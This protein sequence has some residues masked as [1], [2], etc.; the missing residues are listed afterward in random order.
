M[1]ST[2]APL[3]VSLVCIFIG[4][5]VSTVAMEKQLSLDASCGP[6]TVFANAVVSVATMASGRVAKRTASI[7]SVGWVAPTIPLRWHAIIALLTFAMATLSNLSYAHGVNVP[8]HV[9]VKGPIGLPVGMVIGS[10]FL[11]KRYSAQHV[12]AIA[13][14][15][16]G[17]ACVAGF[18]GRSGDDSV[19]LAML[20]ASV[21]MQAVL[22][23][24]QET[25]YA[26]FGR[27]SAETGEPLWREAMF[28]SSLGSLVL[29]PLLV[30]GKLAG[31]VAIMAASPIQTAWFLI[32]VAFCFVGVCGI[33]SL[34]P[35][36]SAL[37]TT[38][39]IVARKAITLV[40]SVFL[41]GSDFNAEQL[42]GAC[43]VFAGVS[44]YA[45]APTPRIAARRAPAEKDVKDA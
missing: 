22:G 14:V 1:T 23:A 5:I 2:R 19:G 45:G 10:I 24:L 32:D 9:V 42:G 31:S 8:T 33:Y 40:I 21:L 29:F 37:T 6:I 39:V 3:L 36:T 18:H 27:T 11:R 26:R 20:G 41:L 25:S 15:I 13:L 44:L 7:G 43:A 12:V 38:L 17:V 30:G 28:F 35:L 16:G 34:T 4:G